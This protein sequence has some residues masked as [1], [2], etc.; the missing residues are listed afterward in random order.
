MDFSIASL[1]QIETELKKRWAFPYHWHKK[2][3]N[4]ADKL[5][6][7]IFEILYFE[8]LLL[9]IERQLA[10]LPAYDKWKDYALNRWYNYWS[11]VAVE[12]ILASFQGIE[13][14]PN[15][16]HQSIDFFL[17]GI[18]FD[19][20]TT[21]FPFGYTKTQAFAEENPLHLIHWLYNSQ[22]H[23]QRWHLENR[24]FLVCYDKEGSHWHLKAEIGLIEKALTTYM[25][26]FNFARLKQVAIAD[27]LI[28]TDLVWVKA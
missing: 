27:N 22:S 25:R 13:A 7:F 14:H 8:D 10:P 5:T 26:A 18:P 11:S 3:D 17:H 4:K 20:K 1:H 23:E 6:H 24:L 21:V 9:E 28:W 2:Q 15:E 16:K 19:H 12:R